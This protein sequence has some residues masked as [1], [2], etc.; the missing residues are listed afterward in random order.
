MMQQMADLS[1]DRTKGDTA[2]FTS[3]GVDYF[4]PLLVRIGR[5]DHK[6]MAAYLPVYQVEGCT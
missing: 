6:G 4:V 3:T 5:S 2:P 1:A